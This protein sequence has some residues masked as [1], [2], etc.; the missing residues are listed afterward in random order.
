MRTAHGRLAA[1]GRATAVAALALG[2]ATPA[3]AQFGGLKKRLKTAATSTQDAPEPGPVAA[4]GGT[5]VLDAE[6]VGRLI[7]G[8]RAAESERQAAAKED[9]PYGRYSE[10]RKAYEVAQ[11]KCEQGRQTFPNRMAANERLADKYN[12]IVTRMVEA[13]GRGDQRAYQAYADSA[14]AMQDPACAVKQAE[15]PSDYYEA[16]RAVEERAE[17]KAMEGSGFSRGELA[18]VRERAEMAL[19]GG[20]APGDLSA[21]EKSAVSAR[22]SELKPL[23]GIQDPP[24]P[25]T[26]AAGTPTPAAAPAP[27]PEPAVPAGSSEMAHCYAKNAQQHEKRIRALGER[28]EAARKAGDTATLLAVADTIQQLQTAG[29][30][31]AR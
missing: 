19:R 10:A 17:R 31:G 3:A 28:G 20:Q 6:V 14:A 11:P 18:L 22:A 25:Q 26:V 27:Q 24:P 1:I 29:C 30:T 15:Q 5:I 16:H 2:V 23:L 9:T 7:A 13:Q 21:S 12:E 8:L 4:N